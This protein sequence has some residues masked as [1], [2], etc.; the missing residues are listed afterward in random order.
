MAEGIL[1]LD[2]DDEITSAAAR[3]RSVPTGRVAVVLP[4]GSRVATSRINFRLL[5]RDAMTHEKRLSVVASDAA[6]RALAASAGLPVF[7]TVQEYE[8]SLGTTRDADADSGPVVAAS[9]AEVRRAKR[10][11]GTAGAT[12]AA[13]AGAAAAVGAVPDAP[14]TETARVV[15]PGD[16]GTVAAAAASA[17]AA[18]A[19]ATG[20]APVSAARSP[21]VVPMDG[22]GGT[23]RPEVTATSSRGGRR[24]NSIVVGLAVLALAL[25]VGGVGAYVLLPSATIV[26]TPKTE[27]L[28]PIQVIV[29]ADPN[30]TQPDA[31]NATVPAQ[32]LSVDVTASDTFPSTGKRVVETAATGTVRF[33][34]LD[35]T[36]SNTIPAGSIVSSSGGI[37]FRTDASVTVDAATLD[38]VSLAVIPKYAS[39]AVTAIRSGPEGNLG[40]DTLQTIPPGEGAFLQVTNPTATTGGSRQTFPKVTQADVDA[41][42]VSLNAMLE[43]DLKTQVED[44]AL[45]PAGTT[46]FPETAILGPTTPTVDPASLVGTEAATF[47]LG[48]SATGTVIA[49]DEGPVK[50]IAATHLR[51]SVAG[52]SQLVEDSI[53]IKIGTP[54]VVGQTVKFPVTASATQVAVLDPAALEAKILGKSEAEAKAILAPYGTAVIKLSP[55]WVTTIPTFENRVDLTIATGSPTASPGAS[56]SP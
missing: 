47:D 40:P 18:G 54:V 29:T 2:V 13:G 15:T 46:V 20:S 3:V 36:S 37:R 5:A 25:L 22:D 26:V 16:A 48:L 44:P 34:N 21:D 28:G 42:L 53:E 27:T 7:A 10:A 38:L 19:L 52:G 50:T 41:A 30:T 49:V 56:P 39:I 24:R 55:D 11:A 1:Y 45:A 23:R 17:G 12:G 9:A 8:A 51:G 33:K 14:S 35:P 6:T 31:A 4:Y 43:A 32:T